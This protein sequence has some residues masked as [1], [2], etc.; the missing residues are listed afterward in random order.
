M[1]GWLSRKAGETEE[2]RIGD[3]VGLQEISH[4]LSEGRV[5]GTRK[6]NNLGIGAKY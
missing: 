1:D 6:G 4:D 2:G 3:A 5:R